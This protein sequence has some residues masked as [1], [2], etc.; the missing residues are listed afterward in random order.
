[1]SAEPPAAAAPNTEILFA[2]TFDADL[3]VTHL[4]LLRR[5]FS[6]TGR[7]RLERQ[8]PGGHTTALVLLA[9]PVRPEG[10]A[11]APVVVKLDRADAI[12]DEAQRY[13]TVVQRTLPA[14]TAR[15][16]EPPVVLADSNLAGLMYTFVP[17]DTGRIA[18]LD[19]D[20]DALGNWLRD[21]LYPTFGA[22]WW[23]QRRPYR[24]PGLGGV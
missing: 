21:E 3:P 5:M 14:L 19:L 11:D 9:T 10:D 22:T 24:I 6:R 2:D 23:G 7:V 8:L 4:Q 20:G 13:E 12:L 17:G 16:I 15:L 18:A 1:M